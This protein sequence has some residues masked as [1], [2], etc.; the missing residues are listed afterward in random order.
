[1]SEG[2]RLARI[3]DPY[4]GETIETLYAPMDGIIF[5]AH[6]EPLTYAKTAVFKMVR[7]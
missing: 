6:N 1:M 2:Q 7:V 3:I 4:E 5:F